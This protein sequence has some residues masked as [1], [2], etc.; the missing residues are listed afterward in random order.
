MSG[1]DNIVADTLS[2]IESTHPESHIS[3]HP[4]I[5]INYIESENEPYLIQQL[6]NLTQLQIND[7]IIGEIINNLHSQN[8]N[9]SNNFYLFQNVLYKRTN[10]GWKILIPNEMINNLIWACHYH[11]LHCGADKCLKLLQETFIFKNMGRKIRQ[12][13]ACCDSC[14]RCKPNTH[15]NYGMAKGIS[16]INK[17]IQVACD[18]IGPLPTSTFGVKYIFIMVD[19]F[20]KFVQLYPVKKAN[21][22]T[23]IDKI[24][25]NYI[26][27]YGKPQY[28]QSDNGTSFKS[29]RYLRRLADSDITPIF[30]PIRYPQFNI[31]ERYIQ[32]V[33]RTIRTTC[34][35][36]QQNWFNNLRR[37]NRCL[38]E[39]HNDTTGYTPNELQLGTKDVRFWEEYLT[40][41]PSE[42]IPSVVKLEQ[43]R[44]RIRQRQRKNADK[45]NKQH[46]LTEFNVGDLVLIAQK[47]QSRLLDRTTAKLFELFVGPFIICEKLGRNVYSVTDQDGIHK[48]GPYHLTS[49]KLY[50][51][52]NEQ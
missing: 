7:P 41:P 47:P 25:N 10:L 51:Q 15:P 8:Q 16:C 5:I 6:Q 11:Y 36:E 31:A 4:S 19:L 33:K 21:T 37:I 17:N 32:N 13:I 28:L 40:L 48:R 29:V 42:N 23:A 14:Q 39:I 3:N 27:T 1:K 45:F 34:H 52:P 49:L 26:P 12:L 46:K 30:N 22:T 9:E 24:F 50:R 35:H 2:R 38:N 43:A 18:W 44:Q 20:T